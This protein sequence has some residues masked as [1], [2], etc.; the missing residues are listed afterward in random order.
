MYSSRDSQTGGPY[1]CLV[2]GWESY[3]LPPQ[4]AGEIWGRAQM[5]TSPERLIPVSQ[6]A[7]NMLSFCKHVMLL[8]HRKHWWRRY[9]T[10]K[11]SRS[12]F[13]LWVCVCLV[14]GKID[15][16]SFPQNGFTNIYYPYNCAHIRN[17]IQKN[18]STY[19]VIVFSFCSLPAAWIPRNCAL[20]NIMCY[21]LNCV[22]SKFTDWSSNHQCDCI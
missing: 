7:I 12:P 3:S 13:Y 22:S 21:G 8:K 20:C 16:N 6:G 4:Q 17:K 2:T 10:A 5:A 15:S 11:Y 9:K 18:K 14:L 1:M 19:W